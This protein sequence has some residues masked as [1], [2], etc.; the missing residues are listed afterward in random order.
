MSVIERLAG[1][2]TGATLAALLAVGHDVQDIDQA[3]R[4]GLVRFVDRDYA[5]PKGLKVRWYYLNSNQELIK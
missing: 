2:P 1:C 3:V 4:S 5:K